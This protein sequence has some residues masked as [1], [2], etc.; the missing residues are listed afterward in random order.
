MVDQGYSAEDII[1]EITDGDYEILETKELFY[2]CNCSKE[3]FARGLKS[4]G[5]DTLN[6][7]LTEDKKAEITCNFCNTKYEFNED[8]LKEIIM[9]I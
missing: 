4:L 6:E 7:I 3:R 5:K 2:E 1:K 9:S 8:D